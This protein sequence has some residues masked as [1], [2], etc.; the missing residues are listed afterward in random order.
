AVSTIAVPTVEVAPEPDDISEL[1]KGNGRPVPGPE[2]ARRPPPPPPADKPNASPLMPDRAEA[3]RFLPLLDPTATRF[4]FQTFDD[5]K[6]RKNQALARVLHGSL[7]D[8]FA[9]LARLNNLGAGIFVTI[10]ETNLRGRLATDIVKVRCLFGDFD[11]GVPLPQ[12]GPRRFMAVQS[13]ATG[14]HG[15]WKPNGVALDAFTPTQQLIAKRFNGQP[16]P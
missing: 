16:N 6:E 11:N 5:D 15:Y 4:T 8:C 3:A 10:N 14:R 13:S 7:D 1:T 2:E 12:D 9:E